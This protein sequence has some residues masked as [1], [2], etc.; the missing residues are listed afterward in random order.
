MKKQDFVK[1]PQWEIEFR[2]KIQLIIYVSTFQFSCIN[3][4][5]PGTD[6]SNLMSVYAKVV[7]A[8]ICPCPSDWELN[9]HSNLCYK[10]IREDLKRH[11]CIVF[12]PLSFHSM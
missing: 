3:P 12:F 2:F 1:W 8:N 10:Y 6:E 7:N 5:A 11:F 9:E 4:P